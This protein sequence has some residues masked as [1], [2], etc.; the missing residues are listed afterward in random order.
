[1]RY[2]HGTHMYI[3][4]SGTGHSG[5]NRNNI[6]IK[7]CPKCS[8]SEELTTSLQRTK[9]PQ[10]P[11][12]PLFNESKNTCYS[13]HQHILTFYVDHFVKKPDWFNSQEQFQS[14]R[15]NL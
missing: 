7:Q 4:Y 9:R 3:L 5:H 12:C 13:I 10:D 8:F 14:F 6:S 15:T 11:M 2:V 1:M